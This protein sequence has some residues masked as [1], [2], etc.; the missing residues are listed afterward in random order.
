MS[1]LKIIPIKIMKNFL[2]NFDKKIPGLN[3]RYSHL[4]FPIFLLFY[5]IFCFS[6]YKSYGLTWDEDVTYNMGKSLYQ[7]LVKDSSGQESYFIDKNYNWSTYYNNLYPLILYSLNHKEVIESYHLLNLLF[8]AL[9]FLA[10]Y[11]VTFKEYKKPLYALM[12][13]IFIFLTPRFL[14]DLPANPKDIPFAIMY[15]LSLVAIYLFS[16]SS[17]K[18]LKSLV[19]GILFGV[20]HSLRILGFS[21]YLILLT[22]DLWQYFSRNKFMWSKKLAIFLSQEILSLVLIFICANFVMVITWPYLGLNYFQH[23]KEIFLVAREFPIT[24]GLYPTV[25]FN[26]KIVPINEIQAIYIPLWL[27]ITTPL[28]ILFFFLV[29]PFFYKNG[30]KNK[31]YLLFGITFLINLALYFLLKPVVYD[32]IRHYLFIL[33]VI[34]ILAFIS[35]VNFLSLKLK[36]LFWLK[37]F[38]LILTFISMVTTG[39]E[40]TRLHPYEYVYFNELIGGL[41]GAHRKFETDYWG[42]S[43]KEAADWINE[44]KKTFMG[45]DKKLYISSCV[46]LLTLYYL[47]E[48]IVMDDNLAKLSTCYTRSNLDETQKGQVVHVVQRE[49]IPL[50]VIKIIQK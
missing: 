15:F 10:A 21:L 1:N 46:E 39:V 8:G 44:N 43:F 42:A 26:G 5:L 36:K 24:P 2:D 34:A 20:S 22:F 30:L 31:L 28:F 35:F 16:E 6:T 40:L 18:L 38:I 47:D 32:G 4:L 3:F 41:R 13:V 12:G 29:S 9:I 49:G 48:D 25:L 45:N 14:G 23:L 7:I 50:N 19:L 11:I 33:P 17:N 27:L 37:I